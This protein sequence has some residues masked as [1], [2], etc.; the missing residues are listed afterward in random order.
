MTQACTWGAAL[1]VGP[2]GEPK[3]PGGRSRLPYEHVIITDR[4]LFFTICYSQSLFFA[5]MTVS[6]E[7]V[8]RYSMRLQ[9]SVQNA[10]ASE[11]LGGGMPSTTK[12]LP[13]CRSCGPCRGPC[14]PG[15]GSAATRLKRYR[16]ALQACQSAAPLPSLLRWRVFWGALLLLLLGVSPGWGGHTAFDDDYIHCPSRLRLPALTAVQVRHSAARDL[17]VEWQPPAH[18]NFTAMVTARLTGPGYRDTQQALLGVDTLRFQAPP[19][20]SGQALTLTLAV[21]D[22]GHVISDLYTLQLTE[23]VAVP[24]F[25]TPFIHAADGEEQV[26]QGVFH[27]LGFQHNFT[28]GYVDTGRLAPATPRFRIG[29]RHG[30]S[31]DPDVFARFRLRL[32]DAKGNNVLGYDP[33]TQAAQE[34]YTGRVLVLG[35]VD[36]SPR[37]S[38]PEPGTERF[39]TL[40]QSPRLPHPA[41]A[42]WRSPATRVY[43]TQADAPVIADAAGATAAR[44]PLLFSNLLARTALVDG[45]LYAEPPDHIYDLPS[46]LFDR[47]GVY[48]LTAWAEDGQQ[49]PISASCRIT[50]STQLRARDPAL[51]TNVWG[52]DPDLGGNRLDNSATHAGPGRVLALRLLAEDCGETDTT[53]F[54]PTPTATPT[55]AAVQPPQ[56]TTPTATP[57]PTPTA[58]ASDSVTLSRPEGV[59]RAVWALNSGTCTTLQL[60]ATPDGGDAV[61][62]T[63]TG[64][65]GQGNRILI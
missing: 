43:W 49:R 20:V 65:S 59:V 60:T 58:A 7:R 15:P 53:R 56:N 33:G 57:T 62:R 24:V 34:L 3:V 22:R 52:Y 11:F 38:L 29:L 51:Y 28:N 46:D 23:D 27:Y 41:P 48:T 4:S 31:Y 35:S 13:D 50:F 19:T 64:T 8:R 5:G 1:E 18:R 21:T 55:V 30:S 32:E 54:A 10:R 26:T 40:E 17:I 16:V 45:D 14:C 6:R 63:L 36:G 47:E 12:N 2:Y 39:G 37:P 42:A 25:W 9:T 61:T 44:W